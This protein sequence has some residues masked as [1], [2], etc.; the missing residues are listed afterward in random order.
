MRIIFLLCFISN[1]AIAQTTINEEGEVRALMEKYESLAKSEEFID[2]WRIKIV[3]TTDRREMERAKYKFSQLYPHIGSKSSYENPYY[4][5]RTGAYQK[6]I[7]LESFL[8]E[9]KGHFRNA[10][11]VRDKIRKE[12]IVLALTNDK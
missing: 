6:R 10:I 7:H 5:V 11:P 9:L 4:S 1:L 8:V 3:N 2:G 12:E